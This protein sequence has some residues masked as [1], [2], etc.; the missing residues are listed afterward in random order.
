[1][2]GPARF[3]VLAREIDEG[4][5]PHAA[6]ALVAHG[7]HPVPPPG[8]ETIADA[9]VE[10]PAQD[11][12]G[13][14]DVLEHAQRRLV[15][16]S[17]V[18]EPRRRPDRVRLG[19]GRQHRRQPR[20]Q[21]HRASPHDLIGLRA[22]DAPPRDATVGVVNRPRALRE[23]GAARELVTQEPVA[24]GRGERVELLVV[25][26]EP[27]VAG[28]EH[29]ERQIESPAPGLVLE[30]AVAELAAGPARGTGDGVLCPGHRAEF[31]CAGPPRARPA[32]LRSAG[33]MRPDVAW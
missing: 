29:R 15:Q 14:P 7:G 20:P 5:R 25:V 4:Q 10:Q 33:R 2:A 13:E 28:G 24:D 19:I 9:P 23:V 30:T 26:L 16:Q 18:R 11:A 1:V 6:P 22:G 8:G 31:M 17:E 12:V 32:R 3:V 27:A 21:P